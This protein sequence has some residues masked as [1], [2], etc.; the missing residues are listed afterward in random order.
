MQIVLKQEAK[1]EIVESY[2]FFEERQHGLGE[3]FFKELEQLFQLI[4]LNPRLFP[5]YR[6][7]LKKVA[8]RRFPYIIIYEIEN[9]SIIVYAV[10]H[11]SRNPA[12][13]F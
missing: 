6:K 1:S 8:M 10:F 2:L 5:A 12:S 4:S 13:R 3:A 11:T 9:T 7:S